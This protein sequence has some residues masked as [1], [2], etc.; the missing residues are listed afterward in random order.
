MTQG[1]GRHPAPRKS[2]LGTW[3]WTAPSLLCSLSTVS[4]GLLR[5]ARFW[6]SS[7][8]NP[9]ESGLHLAAFSRAVIL[10]PTYPSADSILI[11]LSPKIIVPH[12]LP[13]P[14]PRAQACFMWIS[15]R[16]LLKMELSK[17]SLSASSP[18]YQTV[19]EERAER[20]MSTRKCVCRC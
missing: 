4:S 14:T 3:C 18:A 1:P 2:F 16:F 9:H 8:T 10:L 15:P 5:S 17:R 7:P 13:A 20:R 11:F 6:S 12:P 19:L